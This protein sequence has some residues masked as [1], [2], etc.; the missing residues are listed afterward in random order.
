[1]KLKA[2]T[3]FATLIILSGLLYIGGCGQQA[4]EGTVVATVGGRQIMVEEIHSFF[5]RAGVRFKTADFEY[6]T[7]RGFLDSLINQNLLILGAY[8]YNLQNNDEVLRVVEGEKIKFL[9]DVLFEQRI[10]S[11]S[12]PTDAEVEDWYN[13]MGEELKASHVLLSSPDTAEL[14]LDKLKEG[15]PFEELALKYSIDPS[16]KRN[17]GSLD[18]FTW[19]IMVD[20]FQEA[21][22]RMQPGE[23]SAPVKTNHGYHIIKLVDRRPILRRPSFAESKENTRGMIIERRK[24]KLM[25]EFRDELADRFPITIQKPTCV[26]VLNK[27][28]FLYPETIGDIPRWRN[29][30]DP[31]QLDVNEKELVLGA[32]DGGQLTLGEYLMNLRRVT[33]DRRPDFDKY[34]SLADAVFQMS[35]MNILELEAKREGLDESNNYLKKVKYFKELAMADIMRNDSIPASSEIFEDEIFEYYTTHPEPFTKPMRFKILEIQLDD[36][37]LAEKYKRTIKGERNFRDI[38]SRETMR[39]G[40]RLVQGDLGIIL[41]SQYPFLFEEA[42]KVKAG[43]VG[44]PVKVGHRYSLIW[45]LNRME[46]VLQDFENVK[47]FIVDIVTKEKGDRLFEKWVI[48]QKKAVEISIEENV[49]KESIDRSKYVTQDETGGSEADSLS[50]PSDSASSG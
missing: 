37:E 32:Y 44:G 26:F 30:I 35:F 13:R 33:P 14:V 38:A 11:K 31:A 42:K 10:I 46:P 6:E 34:D 23:I 49:L 18:W 5:D 9:L 8:E 45:V 36:K 21:V 16:V 20:N 43:K 17:Q 22:F 28:E 7:K 39:P 4:V 48:A 50:Q 40:K 41:E 15:V 3:I 2:L 12:I 29:N 24:R 27:L 1:M 47:Q 19:G 25:L